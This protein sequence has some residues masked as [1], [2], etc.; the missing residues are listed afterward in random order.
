MPQVQPYKT[1]KQTKKGPFLHALHEADG[2][3]TASSFVLF[4]KV[5][6]LIPQA[7][8]VTSKGSSGFFLGARLW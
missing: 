8:H 5:F 7:M 6:I 3:S 2:L 4:P 1:S